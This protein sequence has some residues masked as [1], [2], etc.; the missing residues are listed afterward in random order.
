[1]DRLPFWFKSD[2][3]RDFRTADEGYYAGQVAATTQNRKTHWANW[4]KYARPL[5]LDPFVQGVE[6]TTRVCALTE[7]AA[8]VRQ[9]LYGRRKRVTT[10]MV[11]GA[12]T[13]VAQEV[14]LV[15]GQNPT[16]V[17][18]SEKLFPRLAQMI[19]G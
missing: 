6:Y 14:A 1:M 12:V 19:D 11:V 7:F 15:C 5:G 3:A 18:G 9:G 17:I 4:S 16:K 8:R 2:Y 10:G 13:A